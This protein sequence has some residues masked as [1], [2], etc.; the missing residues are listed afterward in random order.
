MVYDGESAALGDALDRPFKVVFVPDEPLTVF[1]EKA[2][3]MGFCEHGGVYLDSVSEIG[4][5]APA[6]LYVPSSIAA[7]SSS[8]SH[9]GFFIMELTESTGMRRGF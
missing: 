7:Y 4:H 6:V 1:G 3:D 9:V 5:A 2:V 8:L